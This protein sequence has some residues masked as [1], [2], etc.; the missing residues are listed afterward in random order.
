MAA[1]N[2]NYTNLT[3]TTLANFAND[4]FDGIIKNNAALSQLKKAGNIKEVGG[5]TKFSHPVLYTSNTTFG[6]IGKNGTIA[7]DLQDPL[8]RAEYNIKVL[9]G[10]VAWNL[11]DEAMNS[12]DK[13]KLIDLVESIKYQAESTMSNLMGAQVMQAQSA[14]GAND[15]DSIPYIIS[16]TASTDT[17]AVGGID[18]SATAQTF[19]RP[20]VYS[21]SVSAFNTSNAGLTA[22][23]TVLTNATFGNQG[24]TF[25]ITTK[26]IFMLYMLALTPNVRYTKLDSGDAA[27]QNLLYATLP[28]FFDDNAPASQM[29]FVDGNSLKLQVL[30]QGNMKMTASQPAYNQLQA[31]SLLYFLGDITCGS[32]RT[33]GVITTITG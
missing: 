26:A 8:T 18:S 16:S 20:Y 6:A 30:S 1:G 11:V 9:A 14:V 3:A 23:E 2:T 32:R 21:T 28:V 4:I 17:V 12:G 29:F 27:F 22:M 15:F 33:Q 13:E 19:W 25:I 5:G 10:S 7:T 31:R 24:P